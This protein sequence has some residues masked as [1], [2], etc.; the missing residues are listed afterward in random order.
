[1]THVNDNWGTHDEH[2]PPFYG[3]ADWDGAMRALGEIG[4]SHPLN[5]ELKFKK[6]PREIWPEALDLVRRIGEV[7]MDKIDA[8]R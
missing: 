3:Q 6:L 1:M 5:F 2:I 7:L 8:A 4:Y